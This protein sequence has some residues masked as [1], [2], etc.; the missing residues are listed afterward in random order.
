MGWLETTS[1]GQSWAIGPGAFPLIALP[2]FSEE[3]PAPRWSPPRHRIVGPSEGASTF[4]RE[5]E[6]RLP[7]ARRWSREEVD[8]TSRVFGGLEAVASDGR[9][10]VAQIGTGSRG[11]VET[12]RV[13]AQ[14]ARDGARDPRVVS[15][16]RAIVRD[17]P[18]KDRPGELRALFGYV[19]KHVRYVQD[20]HGLEWV[21][22]PF[23]TLLVDGG[24]DCDDH[25][26]LV[27]ALA[28]A[29]GHAGAFRVVRADRAHPGEFTH[30]Y[31]LVGYRRGDKT[32]WWAADTTQRESVLGW[33]PPEVAGFDKADV[34]VAA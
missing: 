11:T 10:R 22:T 25:A 21:Q 18:S 12:L 29:L 19:K 2:T 31:P 33:E 20:P 9:V 4:M 27:V 34:L 6:A 16:A 5:V 8:P 28:L 7:I 14:L 17:L 26:T 30:V 32:L 15:V 24:G 1:L 3:E 13:M 23:R